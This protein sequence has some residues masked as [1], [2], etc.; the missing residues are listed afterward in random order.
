[1]RTHCLWVPACSVGCQRR[2]P[3]RCLLRIHVNFAILL[4]GRWSALIAALF[5][6]SVVHRVVEFLIGRCKILLLFGSHNS[7]STCFQLF[8]LT[9]V[10][11]LELFVAALGSQMTSCEHSHGRIILV[12][13]KS[14]AHGRIICNSSL[15]G[16]RPPDRVVSYLLIRQYFSHCLLEVR[17]SLFI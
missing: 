1:M 2:A 3:F 9:R 8:C 17:M 6:P 13:I 11:V 5:D 7:L 12:V 4:F 15:L 14:L 10:R 16:T